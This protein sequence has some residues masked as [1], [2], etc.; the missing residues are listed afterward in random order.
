M[1]ILL[2]CSAGMSTSILEKNLNDYLA[3]QQIEGKA[4]AVSAAVA[5]SMIDEY[6]IVL[7]GPQVRFMLNEFKNLAG[8]KIPVAI[9]EPRDYAMAKAENIVVFAQKLLADFK[10]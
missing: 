4:L 9:I 6:D 5:K 3:S 2:A 10:A 8:D 7:L 1:K